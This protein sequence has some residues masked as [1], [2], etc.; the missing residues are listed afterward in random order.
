MILKLLPR[1][2]GDTMVILML[3]SGAWCV[4]MVKPAM[5]EMKLSQESRLASLGGWAYLIL[6]LAGYLTKSITERYLP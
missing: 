1:I 3:C 2:F 6:A 4:W 5:Q